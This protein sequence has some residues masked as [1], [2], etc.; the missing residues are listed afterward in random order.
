MDFTLSD[1]D[2]KW[3]R[4]TW[5]RCQEELKAATGSVGYRTFQDTVTDLL[6]RERAWVC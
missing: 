2:T 1:D 3:I 4:E 5:D 6:D